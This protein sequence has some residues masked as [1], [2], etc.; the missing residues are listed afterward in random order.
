[1]VLVA[2]YTATTVKTSAVTGIYMVMAPVPEASSGAPDNNTPSFICRGTAANRSPANEYFETRV[3]GHAAGVVSSFF[4]LLAATCGFAAEGT[5]TMEQRLKI[6]NPVSP[7]GDPRGQ[8]DKT[9]DTD[10][11]ETSKPA[12]TV[13]AP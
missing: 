12:D 11:V 1:M 9:K 13:G 6:I 3:S 7:K 2:R 5:V 8:T 4:I 10:A